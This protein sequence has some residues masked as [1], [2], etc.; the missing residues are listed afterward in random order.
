ML[1]NKRLVLAHF[2]L[3]FVL[4]GVALLLGA[5]QMLVRSPLH[6]WLK[7]P[8]LYY[9]SVTEHGT[10]MGYAFPT[11]I[12]MGFG[13]AVSEL[14]LKRPLVG[15][16]FAWLG[17][18]LLALGAVTA[19]VPVALGRASVLYTFYPPMIGNVFYYLGVVLVVVGSWVW[20]ALMS[21]NLAA[22]KRENRGK[23]VPL[24]MFATVAGAYLWGWTAVGAAIEVLFQILPV[25]LGWR[26]TIDAGLARVFFSWTLHA[27]VYFWLMPAY[28][29]YYTIIPRAIGGRL[30]SDSMARI[31]FILFLVVAMPIGLHHLFTDP[32]VGS[33]F[34]FLQS[35]FTALVAVPT[36]LTVFTICASVEIAGRLRGGKGTFG[37]IARLPWHN[38]QM[39]ALAFSFVMLGF[40]GAGGLINMSYQ[41]DQSIHNTQWVTGHF[42]LIYGGAIV[43]MY[44]AIAYDLWPQLTGRELTNWRLMRWQL[45]LWFVGMIVTTFPWHLV[46]LLG[47]PRRMAYFDY[48]DPALAAQASLVTLSAIGGFILVIS[49][50]LF[51]V[52]LLQGHRSAVHPADDYRFSTP[53]HESPRLPVALNSFALWVVLMVGLTVVNYGYPIAQLLETPNTAV[54]AIPIGAPR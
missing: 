1:N 19:S 30:Y 23:P 6:P 3:A 15:V 51:F 22:W 14:A 2:W 4:F 27:I 24:A 32:Q 36:L 28:I 46:G 41:L 16:R 20:V 29:A 40:G 21:V 45:W 11:L 38:P 31:S 53:V 43:I 50:V 47:M 12:A 33:G 44:F 39:L 26:N 37:W 34:K 13:Y 54:P 49:V 8:E 52:V 35:V 25:A 48:S 17:F 5:W 7:N 10:V 9:R 42:H 18:I